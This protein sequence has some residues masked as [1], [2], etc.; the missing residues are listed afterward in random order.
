MAVGESLPAQT[1]YLPSGLALTTVRIF[2]DR[3][4][5]GQR[6]LR[7]GVGVAAAIDHRHLG[8]TDGGEGTGLDARFDAG[9]VEKDAG[10]AFGRHH[11]GQVG[12]A[13]GVVLGGR[14]QLAVVGGCQQFHVAVDPALPAHFHGGG[15]NASEQAAP[16]G[17]IVQVAPIV[18]QRNVE[19]GAAKYAGGVVDRGVD[20]VALV[21]EDA[22]KAHHIGQ[23]HHLVAFHEV[24][25]D[26]RQ[27]RMDL[28]VDEQPAA[29]IRTVVVAAV[30]VV[31]VAAGV[32]QAAIG[33]SAHD[34]FRFIGRTPA[35][36]AVSVEHRNA[37]EGSSG[38]QAKYTHF[39]A[40]AGADEGIVGIEL[41]WL[42]VLAA[43]GCRRGRACFRLGCVFL[44]AR[45]AE[46][47][48]GAGK[49]D[50]S[51]LA[52]E[53]AAAKWRFCNRVDRVL[54]AVHL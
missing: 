29:V 36:H 43:G 1:K 32:L 38:W 19:L 16:L 27:A 10:V 15:V 54:L 40:V 7:I 41:A 50:N 21:R 5:A 33:L 9:H 53:T 22:V 31:G 39:A 14:G 2:A 11:A 49:A 51:R 8:A 20:R 25:A 47:G 48:A 35:D 6:R 17:R 42:D 26:T 37:L 12:A 23:A 30:H 52:K 46:H 24:H 34:G 3:D 4:V 44:A 18:G 13:F 45:Q 28:V